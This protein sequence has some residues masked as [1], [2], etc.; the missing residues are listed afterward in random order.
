MRINFATGNQGKLKEMRPL[1]EDRGHSLEQV[2]AD[3][4]ELDAVD[5]E[6][7]ARQKVIDSFEAVGTEGMLI[8]EDTGF[9]VEG[10]GGFP[11]SEAAYFDETAGAD[12]LLD[13]MR[14]LDDR[15]A[16]FKTVIAVYVDGEI[17]V[18]T[19]KM[20]GK[21]PEKKRGNSHDHLPYNSFFIPKKAEKSLAENPELKDKDFHRNIAVKKFLDWLDNY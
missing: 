1:F 7:V 14:D 15:S 20:H 5:V 8:V 10:I 13:L 21:I 9:Y 18:F 17:E 19:G 2:E 16:Y 11:G 4:S 12:R 3:V 6:D